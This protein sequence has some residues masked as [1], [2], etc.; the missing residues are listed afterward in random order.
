MVRKRC[1][2]CPNFQQ[3]IVNGRG[4][5]GG[6]AIVGQAPGYQEARRGRIFTGRSGELLDIILRELNYDGPVYYTNA[7]SCS[8]EEISTAEVNT[9]RPSLIEE[10]KMVRPKKIVMLG[11]V[12]LSALFPGERALTVLR[13][14]RLWHEELEAWCV[15]TFHT[16][17]ALREPDVFRDIL[18]D[19][20]LALEAPDEYVEMPD[21]PFTLVTNVQ[22]FM[23]MIR[24]MDRSQHL[25]L[26]VETTGFNPVEDELLTIG[27]GDSRTTWIFEASL[28]QNSF[29][30]INLE[31]ILED[32]SLFWVT[33]NGYPFDWKWFW[34]KYDIDWR[35][36]ADTM[37]MHYTLDERQGG[38]RL[39]QLCRR[40]LGYPFWADEVEGKYENYGEMPREQLYQYQAWDV[41]GT[42]ELY[43]VLRREMID[44]DPDLIR[45]HDEIL[46]PGSKALALVELNGI[47]IDVPYLKQVGVQLEDEIEQTKAEL[48]AI[49]DELGVTDLKGAIDREVEAREMHDWA[50]QAQAEG[51]ITG[52]ERIQIRAAWTRA[53]AEVEANRF[54]PNS[55]PQVKRLISQRLRLTYDTTRE[56]LEAIA[57]K[58]PAPQKIVE[59]RQ[60][61]KLKGTYVDGII[62]RIWVSDGRLHG[63]FVIIGTQT[64]RLSSR[65]PNLQNIPVLIGPIIRLAFRASPG[66]K[67]AEIDNSQV[68]LRI[69]GVFSRNERLIDVYRHGRDIHREV[70]AT[71]FHKPAEAITDRERYDAKY[72]DFP[73]LYGATA[74]SLVGTGDPPWSL[75]TARSFVDGFLGGFPDL[76]SWLEHQRRFVRENGYVQTLFGRY[77]RFPLILDQNAGD[78]ERQAINSPIQG[79]ASDLCF[80]A[81]TRIVLNVSGKFPP[82]EVRVLLTVHDSILIEAPA[83]KI[84]YYATLVKL[85]MQVVPESWKAIGLPFKADIKIGDTWGSMKS[86]EPG[87]EFID[88]VVTQSV[89]IQE[90]RV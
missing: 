9:C 16:A 24:T 49:T 40:Y 26:D 13:P 32:P 76:A 72:V 58:H 31:M 67:L 18:E 34:K 74:E 11:A 10:L 2:D 28:L 5:P 68:E 70:A 80:M 12:A 20:R 59:V 3:T 69:A 45:V 77:R 50:V 66:W 22:E 4:Q 42:W 61:V 7:L 29:I 82:S 73:I 86:F 81:L 36:S 53:K 19:I 25:S 65:D 56:G 39:K 46:L 23:R 89:S 1:Q 17:N 85:E 44:Y 52:R 78:I 47:C 75:S 60:K 71:M 43:P 37:L 63:D 33:Q 8:S 88:A 27:I 35:I 14:A 64:G 6:L 51:K 87:Q 62:L 38:H 55:S 54:N 90:A 57:H 79:S 21:P 15:P 41:R 48:Q 83:D 84:A 30:R